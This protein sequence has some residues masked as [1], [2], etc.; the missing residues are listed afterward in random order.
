MPT[1]VRLEQADHEAPPVD[2]S[3][4][5]DHF[6]PAQDTAASGHRHRAQSG[7]TLRAAVL[8]AN[9]GLV[10]N[11]S[12]VMGMAVPP[13]AIARYFWRAWP[14]WS[15]GLLDGAGR[16]AVGQQLARVL[17]GTDHRTCRTS[18]GGAEG[19]T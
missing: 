10:S 18:G 5:R 14:G 19:W 15:R 7:N 8:G 4:H 3:G 17:S 6:I 16:V 1:V 2:R 9:D 13:P 12:L 11:V